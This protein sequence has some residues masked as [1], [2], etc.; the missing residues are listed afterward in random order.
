MKQDELAWR[1]SGLT[2]H[3]QIYKSSRNKYFKSIRKFFDEQFKEELVAADHPRLLWS[4]LARCT[5]Y[6]LKKS[7]GNIEQELSVSADMFAHY[8]QGKVST[9]IEKLKGTI[10]DNL[11]MHSPNFVSNK[12]VINWEPVTLKEVELNLK[13]LP[14][15]KCAPD[16]IL[17]LRFLR[18][19]RIFSS[20]AASMCNTSLQT[21]EY[22]N[23]LKH[24]VIV[25]VPKKFNNSLDD[26]S[27][28]RPISNLKLMSKLLERLVASRIT[29]QLEDARFLHPNQSSYRRKY[30][31][32][33]ATLQVYSEWSEA[34][35]QGNV[36]IVASLDVSAAFDTVSHRILL[37]R[38]TQ[39][40]II[41]RAR[42][43]I[44]SY[45]SGRTATVL[46]GDQRSSTFSV[47]Y[48]V[49]QG[50]VL[51]PLLFNIYMSDLAR[52]LEAK[53]NSVTSPS[54]NFHIY[55]D[56]VL[57]Y[58]ICTKELIVATMVFL[59]QVIDFVSKWMNENCLQLN[60][61][62]TELFLIRS[63]RQTVQTDDIF[64]KIYNTTVALSGKRTIKWLGVEFDQHLKMDAFIAEKCK[65]CFQV[66]RMLRSIRKK[67][68]WSTTLL[69][70]NA[71]VFSRLDYCSSLLNNVDCTEIQRLDRI[72]KLAARII[73]GTKRYQHI[74]PALQKLQWLDASK[75][76]KMKM[77]RLVFAAIHLNLPP[78]LNT[79]IIK[80]EPLRQLRSSEKQ[81]TT[82]VLGTCRRRIGKGSFKLAGPRIWN[83]LNETVRE[84]GLS[85]SIFYN[86]LFAYL[87][88]QNTL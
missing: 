79:A 48:G 61:A 4:K 20:V 13:R 58:V 56:D 64:I 28:Y 53:I 38:L 45:L 84:S 22:P 41:G 37:Y 81:V 33:T 50:S 72:I 76:A 70:T 62:K 36:V 68:S 88:A 82:L 19:S 21:A 34:L 51:G 15:N 1:T 63:P 77:A 3:R 25:P 67:L 32:E 80:Y 26:L 59:S 35:D 54:F 55:A 17:P 69:L 78:A 9:I 85:H 10:V 27:N 24:A 43:W 29:Q 39:A 75:R 14:L 42:D 8:F 87:V 18:N 7:K 40:G 71:L 60:M 83:S 74:T 52:L 23:V 44:K 16:D 5:G 6:F 11:P 57:L 30:S 49:P 86:R 31:T 66:L 2:V 73:T 47:P 65:K 46:Y 12:I